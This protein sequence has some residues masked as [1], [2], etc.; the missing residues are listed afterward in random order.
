MVDEADSASK[1]VET[2][3]SEHDSSAKQVVSETGSP[4]EETDTRQSEEAITEDEM[5]S[6]QQ[7]VQNINQNKLQIQYSSDVVFS[8]SSSVCSI[9]ILNSEEESDNACKDINFGANRSKFNIST[10]I[11]HASDRNKSNRCIGTRNTY[12]DDSDTESCVSSCSSVDSKDLHY[13]YQFEER[14]Y[15][16]GVEFSSD[17]SDDDGNDNNTLITG[18]NKR[19]PYRDELVTSDV[20]SESESENE[21]YDDEGSELSEPEDIRLHRA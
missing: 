4:L 6:R 8:P 14:S 21:S 10:S 3:Q 9:D 18:S 13:E 19:I 12:I 5:F 15:A 1:E 20:Y 17:T 16:R 7:P 2:S 11:F